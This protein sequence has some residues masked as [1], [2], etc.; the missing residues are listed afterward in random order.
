MPG[1][2]TCEDR[3]TLSTGPEKCR[4]PRESLSTSADERLRLLAG[5]GVV[6]GNIPAKG[7]GMNVLRAFIGVDGLKVQQMP[8]DRVAQADSVGP[9]NIAGGP[10]DFQR[11]G[12]IVHLGHGN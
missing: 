2:P 10:G 9:Q 8:Y 6:S 3:P 7:E 1:K 12:C 5:E 11:F 4:S